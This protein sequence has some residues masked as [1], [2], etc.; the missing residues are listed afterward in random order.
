MGTPLSAVLSPPCKDPKEPSSL[1]GR[2]S[3][4]FSSATVVFDL[5]GLL[6][7][8]AH[9]VLSGLAAAELGALRVPPG[10][11]AHSAQPRAGPSDTLTTPLHLSHL[12]CILRG[13]HF[14]KLYQNMFQ[15]FC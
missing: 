10:D 6:G 11:H 4:D 3:F 2:N 5:T 14:L 8:G 12:K 1:R 9:H 15:I 7:H 13:L